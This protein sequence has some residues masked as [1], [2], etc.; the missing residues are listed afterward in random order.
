MA[1]PRAEPQSTDGN[2]EA[3]SVARSSVLSVIVNPEDTVA[4][5]LEPA[6][7]SL[8]LK[9]EQFRKEYGGTSD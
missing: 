2:V 8:G 5:P 9:P 6:Y 3:P 7:I 4:M 1:G